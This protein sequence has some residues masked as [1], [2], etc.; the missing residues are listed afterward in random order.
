MHRSPPDIPWNVDYKSASIN[1]YVNGKP[2][3]TREPI[4]VKQGQRVMFR[5]VNADASRALNL[6]LAGHKFRV[7]AMDGNPVPTP[8]EEDAL[9]IQVAERIDAVV[10]MNHP[11][12]WILGAPRDQERE[13]GMHAWWSNTKAQRASRSGWLRHRVRFDLTTFGSQ[14][15][16]SRCRTASSK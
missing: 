8:R 15:A 4:R 12:K 2:I 7:V 3:A 6:A 16:H 10:E 5:V 9:T 13:I 14:L 11:G 1:G